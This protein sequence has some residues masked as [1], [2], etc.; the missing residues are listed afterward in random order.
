M[1]KIK[2]KNETLIPKII[3][4]LLSFGLWIYISNVENPV[5]TYEVK[6]IPVEL[7]NLD[8]LTN[9]NFAV[10]ENQNF[11]VDLKLEGPSTDVVKV[12]PEDFK[13]VADMSTYALKIGENTIP[14]QIISY[15]ENITIKNNGFLGIKVNLEELVKKDFTIQSKVKISYRDN[16]YEMNR[17]V[18]PD[19]VTVSGGSSTIDKISSAVISGEESGISGNFE[20]SYNIKFIDSNGDEVTGVS[21]N[22]DTAKLSVKV[23]NGKS[24]PIDLKTTGTPKT[25]LELQGYELSSNYVNIAGSSD[26]LSQVQYI[27]TEI[28]DISQLDKTSEINVKLLVPEGVIITNG[29]EY[30]KVTVTL[31]AQ[32]TV[33]KKLDVTIQYNNLKD[34]LNLES[35]SEKVGVTVSGIQAELDKINEGSLSA[36]LDLSNITDEGSYSNKPEVSFNIP[37]TASITS[38]DQVDIIVKKKI[39]Q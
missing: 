24:V 15:P 5:R 22:I 1:D 16:I 26:V 30:V 12:R 4:L 17:K 29:Q 2:N 18:T 19:T 28:V 35:S 3:S 39:E 31:K 20:K 25:G 14:V 27:D 21:S 10:L 6:N 7:V 11:T 36:I 37:T 38:I 8:S 34:N 9:S 13:I 23:S 32:E 33:S